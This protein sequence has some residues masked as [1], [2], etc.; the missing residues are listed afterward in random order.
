M[1]NHYQWNSTSLEI[2]IHVI[3]TCSCCLYVVIRLCVRMGE[4]KVNESRLTS[5]MR[6]IGKNVERRANV[7]KS[8]DVWIISQGIQKKRTPK[9]V[10]YLWKNSQQHLSLLSRKSTD[11]TPKASTGLLTTSLLTSVDGPVSWGAVCARRFAVVQFLGW[12]MQLY[13]VF[14]WLERM[15]KSDEV[16]N[17]FVIKKYI[18]NNRNKYL[19]EW[20]SRG[21]IVWSPFIS[22]TFSRK[23]L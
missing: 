22:Q 15:T 4:W 20:V 6:L 1:G 14:K 13:N 23:N 11:P 16:Y 19:K 18:N 17:Q 9:P 21:F 7:W 5:L 3:C 8:C 10:F 12:E 2:F